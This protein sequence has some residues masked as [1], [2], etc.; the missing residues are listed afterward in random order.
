MLEGRERRREA[1][2]AS[3]TGPE[4]GRLRLG[5]EE[6]AA[7]AR[8]GFV[9]GE[10]RG[11]GLARY[12]LRFRCAGRQRVKYL[13]SDPARAGRV[14]QELGALQALSRLDRRLA[15]GTRAA[16]RALRAVK[17][18]LGPLLL[19]GYAFRG[20][21]VRRKRRPKIDGRD[22]SS[23]GKER[24]AMDE[25]VE[26][27]AEAVGA[28]AASAPQQEAAAPP[29]EGGADARVRRIMD[30]LRE[31]LAREGALEANLGAVNSDLMLMGY[32]LKRAID[33]AMGTAA[34]LD[35]FQRLMP[36]VES[37]L[38]LTR[39]MERL[40]QLSLRLEA[41]GKPGRE[42]KGGRAATE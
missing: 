31:A 3:V 23:P 24:K 11:P 5:A 18:R 37:Y 40:A 39:Q 26:R 30:L 2:G 38:R 41:P 28:H 32:R 1:A 36:A 17:G 6:L 13:G 22:G 8:Q 21:A 29:A 20:L 16:N 19:P 25:H 10:G 34:A 15:R 27:D 35:Q 33:E 4:L 14:R 7:L 9:C 12:K 42:A